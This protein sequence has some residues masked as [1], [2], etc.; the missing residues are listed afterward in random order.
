LTYFDNAHLS[1]LHIYDCFKRSNINRAGEEILLGRQLKDMK[2]KS[3]YD[4][5]LS[6][7]IFYLACLSLH[8]KF[9]QG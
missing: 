6:Y 3:N 2:K 9:A 4:G 5:G 1:A 8:L 7:N